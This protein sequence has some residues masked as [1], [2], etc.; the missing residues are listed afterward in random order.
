ML[1]SSPRRLYVAACIGALLGPRQLNAQSVPGLNGRLVRFATDTMHITRIERGRE[2]PGG[3]AISAVRGGA[4]GALVL[5]YTYEVPGNAPRVTVT[6]LNRESLRPIE[7]IHDYGSGDTLI[8]RYSQ[9]GAVATRHH[10]GAPLSYA[11]DTAAHGA[12]TSAALD[13]V[14]RALPLR[15]RYKTELSVYFMPL[16]RTERILVRVH[17]SQTLKTRSGTEV[18]CWRLEAQ[19]PGR[20]VEQFWIAKKSRDLIRVLG[21]VSPD[22]LERYD[23]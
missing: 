9:E 19:F 13:L 5:L 16:N 18:G 8:V 1:T 12:F 10:G 17:G 23:R 20:A 7:E 22:T 14:F 11:P 2:R 3:R 15:D 6:R 21:H 4:A